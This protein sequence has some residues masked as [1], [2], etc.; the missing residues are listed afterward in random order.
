MLISKKKKEVF[1]LISSPI[2]PFFMVIPK[3]KKKK[4]VFTSRQLP[5]SS[6]LISTTAFA[7]AS[8]FRANPGYLRKTSFAFAKTA[9]FCFTVFYFLG[10]RRGPWHN[11]LPPRYGSGQNNCV[12]SFFGLPC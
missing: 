4:K 7:D 11:G 9:W 6:H 8:K 10:L 12:S 2:S 1:T 5:H 3:K